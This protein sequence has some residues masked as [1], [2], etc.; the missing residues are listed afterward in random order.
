MNWKI[1]NFEFLM[2]L[3]LISNRSYADLTQYPIFP[4]II[5]NYSGNKI[6]FPNDIRDFTVPMG[7][8]ELSERGKARKKGYINDFKS[9]GTTEMDRP[10]W[11]FGSHYSNST[12]VTHYLT[13]LF[14]FYYLA[15]ELQGEKLDDGNRLFLSVEN[16]F[17]NAT[18][19]KCDI[20]E[21]IPEFYFLPDF[22]MNKNSLYL[23]EKKDFINHTR[24]VVNDVELPEWCDNNPYEFITKMKN[25]LESEEVSTNINNWVDIIFGFKQKGKES[26]NIFNIFWHHT[27]EDFSIDSVKK[28]E[29]ECYL[30]QIEM[31]LCP[32]QLITSKPLTEK[33]SKDHIRK[34]KQLTESKELKHYVN[35]TSSK[36][37]KG[38]E[39]PFML[40]IKVLDNDK[41]MCVF[42]NNTYNNCKFT[43]NDLKYSMDTITKNYITQENTSRNMNKMLDVYNECYVNHPIIIYNQGK[44][45]AQA[46]YWNGEISVSYQEGNSMKLF[47]YTTQ[48]SPILTLTIDKDEQWVYAGSKIGV[49]FIFKVNDY[50]WKLDST[51]YDHTQEIT[52]ISVSNSLNIFATSSLD[53]Y[54]N[55]YTFPANRLFRSIKIKDNFTADYVII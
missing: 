24:H 53:G 44:V 4:W 26:E 29:K 30:T 42:N 5:K 31:G 3:N 41:I 51:L 27:Y 40:K 48:N 23:G 37:S 28:D 54:V 2:W 50:L 22:F 15:I 32:L 14:P 1:S 13:R 21:L 46:A 16:S 38:K 55:L 9:S 18:S 36:F 47:Y 10:P 35:N 20:R 8:M 17:E 45:I 52:F 7:M 33:F 25:S 39:K 12:Y 34:G 6:E 11:V 49:L 43:P 19:L